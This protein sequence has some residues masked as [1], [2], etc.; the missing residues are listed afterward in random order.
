MSAL[1]GT[2]GDAPALLRHPQAGGDA[3]ARSSGL[4]ELGPVPP[5][6]PSRFSRRLASLIYFFYFNFFFISSLSSSTA[7]PKKH[8]STSLQFLE[9]LWNKITNPFANL[10][11]IASG[12]G[13][14]NRDKSV[15]TICL[16]SATGERGRAVGVGDGSLGSLLALPP[17]LVASWESPGE[18]F[19][20]ACPAG[21]GS[22]WG[23]GILASWGG[24]REAG[25]G[26]AGLCAWLSPPSGLLLGAEGV[27]MTRHSG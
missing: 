12:F 27:L 10:W 2:D 14:A 7:C 9:K 17:L 13:T 6:S 3:A 23:I 26:P 22:W 8:R 21:A 1:P 18:G 19:A 5:S 4:A 11:K 20:R 16:P 24:W 15:K 25:A